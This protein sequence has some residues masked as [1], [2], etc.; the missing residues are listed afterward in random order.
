MPETDSKAKNE[1]KLYEPTPEET[2]LT[3]EEVEAVAEVEGTPVVDVKLSKNYDGPTPVFVTTDAIERIEIDGVTPVP[4]P[5]APSILEL[6]YVV[7]ADDD[8]KDD[9]AEED[10]E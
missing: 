3:P 1:R 8:E 10:A 7:A 6:P 9:D 4:A 5:Q 2:D